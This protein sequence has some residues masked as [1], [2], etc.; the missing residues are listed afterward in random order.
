MKYLFEQIEALGYDSPICLATD[1]DRITYI[2]T[3]RPAGDFDRVIDGAG[4]LL[5]PGLY[6]CH[7]H[8]AMT[9]FR[10]YGEDL[11][12]KEWLENRIFPAEDRLTP[13][14]V[15]TACLWAAAEQI[16]SGIVSCSD[17]Y[18]FC[19]QAVQAFAQSGMKANISRSI[20]SFDERES[21]WQSERFLE[22]K[23][24][25]ESY[26]GYADGRIRID[27]SL[28]AEYTNTERTCRELAAYTRE[29]DTGMQL[30]LSET[31]REHNECIA[32]RG[33]TP[34]AFFA[35]CG[36]FDTPT[37]AAHC[38]WLTDADRAILAEKGVC[39]A[40]NPTS[41]LKLASGVMPLK[42]LQDAG[43]CVTLGTD[44]AASN[45]T[46][47]LFKEMHLCALLQKG[48]YGDPTFPR[49]ADVLT[50][51][52]EN[53]ARAQGRPDCGV[54]RV[55][56]KADLVLLDMEQPNTMPH[57][58]SAGAVLY[59]ATPS[60]VAMTVADGTVLYENG[61]WKTLD[62]EAI[63]YEMKDVCAN[64]FKN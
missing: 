29:L 38:V 1:H 24:L 12:L 22:A 23:A 49:A 59:S 13:R 17:M 45:N 18:F 56:A 53:G 3:E 11:P 52:T 19:D 25:Y 26:H 5:I 33:K 14:A 37:T 48:V 30:H 62:I 51:A 2:G 47:D 28:H 40:H 20:V 8:A 54:L 55:G 41:N 32:R 57:Y 7:T 15:K 31:E 58:E 35:D 64:Y 4:K 16:R 39:V 34:A 63:R 61:E 43:V 21:I 42:P 9:L 44:G 50:L 6:N 46:L 27:F 10:G 60:N 36:V